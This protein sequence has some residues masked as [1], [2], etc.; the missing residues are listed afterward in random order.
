MRRVSGLLVHV[1]GDCIY[2]DYIAK[3]PTLGIGE[4]CDGYHM[5]GLLRSHTEETTN[6]HT[7]R[8]SFFAFL[9]NSD[10]NLQTLSS[11]LPN[12]SYRSN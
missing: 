11:Q 9:L 7:I 12:T 6:L 5:V 8:T 10:T 2:K 4:S 1:C 3:R